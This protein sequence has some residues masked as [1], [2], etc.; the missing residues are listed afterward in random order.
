[1]SAKHLYATPLD[2][3]ID[4]ATLSM[5]SSDSEYPVDNIKVHDPA[6]VAKATGTSSTIT[7]GTTSITPVGVAIIN[8]NWTALTLNGTNV[9]LA[10]R[11]SGGLVVNSWLDMRGLGFGTSTTWNFAATSSGQLTIGRLVLLEDIHILNW[12]V[13]GL[14]FEEQQPNITI[15]T[16]YQAKIKYERGIRI[17]SWKGVSRKDAD[18]TAL[19]DLWAA[20]KGQIDPWLLI[21]DASVNDALWVQFKNDKISEGVLEHSVSDLVIEVEELGM[22]QAP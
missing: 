14:Q 11:T 17:R 6:I 1:M 13:N 5:T 7:V 16:F 3:V 22:G 9:P 21:P 18:R 20:A 4:G 2:D 12:L 10:S 8:H 19:L 15:P